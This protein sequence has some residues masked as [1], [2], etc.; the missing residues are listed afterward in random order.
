MVKRSWK[1]VLVFVMLA[2]LPALACDFLSG[3]EAPVDVSE[4]QPVE[5]SDEEPSVVEP[6]APPQ[7]VEEGGAG[8][9]AFPTVVA[10]EEALAQF[11]S[12]RIQT[13]MT[14]EN[15]AEP[16]ES[17]T[18][19]MV[20]SRIIDPPAMGIEMQMSGEFAQDEVIGGE[21]LT[22]SF[23][24]LEGVGYSIVPGLGCISGVGSG[25]M[26]EQFDSS[27][28]TDE[29]VDQIESPEYV[30]EET[31]NG[32]ATYHY[33]FDES[34][35][36]SGDSDLREALG[37]IYVSQEYGYVVRMV[38]DGSGSV[39]EDGSEEFDTIQVEMN[40]VD[41]GE[42]FT[43]EVPAEC[44]TAASDFPVMEGASGFASF[45]GF[46][47]YTVEASL[48]DV[49]A[50]YGEEMAV[51]GYSAAPDGVVTESFALIT[52]TA[53]DQPDVSLNL[54]EDAGTVTVMLT[55]EE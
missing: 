51:R 44:T 36:S 25:E 47:T 3:D 20:T 54:A 23:Y 43:I 21:G 35:L 48:A 15:E 1:W 7:P 24:E 46:S 39:G 10:L 2:S 13:D 52:Y 53:A 8:G 27:I 41:V 49:V 6:T 22:M 18:L 37:D 45:G 11:G 30:G 26:I 31:V 14:F 38:M 32:V 42:T 29:V 34:D 55:T 17:G 50:F 5:R 9:P 40:V 4:E 12:Y 19:S 28:D 33:R 16:S